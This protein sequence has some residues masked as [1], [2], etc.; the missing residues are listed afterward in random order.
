MERGRHAEPTHKGG[1]VGAY[2]PSPRTSLPSMRDVP[3]EC[4]NIARTVLASRMALGAKRPYDPT[5]G[6]TKEPSIATRDSRSRFSPWSDGRSVARAFG[7]VVETPMF[8][9]V[10]SRSSLTQRRLR[11]RR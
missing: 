7:T 5:L 3:L 2:V 9:I 6:L 1:T 8:P 11:E 4:K 10:S